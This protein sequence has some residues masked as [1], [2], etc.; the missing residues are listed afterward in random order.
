LILNIFLAPTYVEFFE[1]GNAYNGSHAVAVF[2]AY[3]ISNDI[4]GNYGGGGI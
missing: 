4:S 3:K 2:N 1:E